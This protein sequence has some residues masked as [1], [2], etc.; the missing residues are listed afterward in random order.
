MI[1]I[2][3]DRTRELPVDAYARRRD[4]RRVAAAR[5]GRVDGVVAGARLAVF[6]AA[7]AIAALAFKADR[8]SGTWLL[9]PAAAFLLAR[10]PR[11]G[12]PRRERAERAVALLRR[13]ASPASRIAPRR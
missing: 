4:V 3:S 9:A 2:A 1:S 6:V 11:P 13:T 12:H 10:H 5:L 7:I 8:L